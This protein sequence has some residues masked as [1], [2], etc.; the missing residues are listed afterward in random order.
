MTCKHRFIKELTPSWKVKYLFVGT[1]NPGEDWDEITC[2]DAAYFYGRP[3]NQFWNILS[4]IFDEKSLQESSQKHRQKKRQLGQS[5]KRKEIG[6]TDLI[7]AIRKE[8]EQQKPILKEFCKKNKIGITDLI[9]SI[10][11]ADKENSEHKDLL[12]GFGDAG[13]DKKK[14]GNYIFDLKFYTEEI[15]CIINKNKAHLKEGGVFLTRKTPDGIKRIWGEWKK[16]EE[17]C[18][19]KGIK[20]KALRSP[21]RGKPLKEWKKDIFCHENNGKK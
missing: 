7:K 11:N 19:C 20:T 16:V 14:D 6:I 10:S 9:K 18:W 15:K 1:F 12:I 8:N 17:Y 13:L 2:N 5:C 21:A 3:R 4:D